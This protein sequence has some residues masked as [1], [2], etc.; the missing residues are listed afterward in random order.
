[1]NMC[2][3]CNFKNCDKCLIENFKNKKD[4]IHLGNN[5]YKIDCVVCGTTNGKI[6]LS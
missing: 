1:L 3:S 5:T 2:H 6:Q 4:K